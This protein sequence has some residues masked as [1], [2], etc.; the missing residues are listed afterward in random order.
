[1][2][3]PS[4]ST[5]FATALAV[6]MIAAPQLGAS[7]IATSARSL[8]PSCRDAKA[9]LGGR[10]HSIRIVAHC[11]RRHGH[12]FGITINR[13]PYR[14]RFALLGYSRH[15]RISGSGAVSR[16]GSCEHSHHG[17]AVGCSARAGGRVTLVAHLRVEAETRC[18]AR[19]F[20]EQGVPDSCQP[21]KGQTCALDYVVQILYSALPRG[22]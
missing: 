7:P 8:R 6:G 5:L 15:P 18:S 14:A 19:V 20:I 4:K 2:R 17:P 11:L 1:M 3:F 22:C 13:N 16:Y 12:E 21:N 9:L 10:P